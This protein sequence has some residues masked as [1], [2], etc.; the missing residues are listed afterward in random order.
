MV[1]AIRRSGD[2][3]T[4]SVVRQKNRRSAERLATALAVSSLR[5]G[6]R[7]ERC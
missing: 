3:A 1:A 2:R 6:V 5:K 4:T 7:R